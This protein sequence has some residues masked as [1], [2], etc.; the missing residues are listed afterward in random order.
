MYSIQ[1]IY[2]HENPFHAVFQK[3]KCY[4]VDMFDILQ[5]GIE[6]AQVA[7]KDPTDREAF[8]RILSDD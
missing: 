1:Q 8:L 4:I 3:A 5:E 7:E 2:I 6:A